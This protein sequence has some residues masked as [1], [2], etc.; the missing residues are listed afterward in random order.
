VAG[1]CQFSQLSIVPGVPDA[2]NDIPLTI[3]ESSLMLNPA[4]A[5]SVG[6]VCVLGGGDGVGVIDCNGGHSN[7]SVLLSRDHNTSP[8]STGNSGSANGLADDAGCDDTALQADGSMSRACV[9]GTKLCNGGINAGMICTVDGDCPAAACVC[10]NT[11]GASECGLHTSSTTCNSPIQVTQSGV[12]GAGD[13]AVALPLALQVLDGA[14]VPPPAQYGD[15]GLACTSDDRV[16]ACSVTTGTPCLVNGHCPGGETC[17]IAPPAAVTVAL[18]TGTNEVRLYDANN[19]SGNRIIDGQS[20]VIATCVAKIIGDGA[21]C[22]DLTAGTLTGLKF[23][24]GFPA[25]DVDP[26]GDIATVFQFTAQ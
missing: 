10:C 24:G 13:L 23:G 7:L 21:T 19:V 12:F 8:G 25:L 6:T 16:G 2:N 14:S 4:A 11:G 18:S 20:C 1:V 15:D 9:E 17:Q 26:T 3:P 22:P 5:G